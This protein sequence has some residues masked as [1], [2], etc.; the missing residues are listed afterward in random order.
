ML[1]KHAHTQHA[2]EKNLIR[3]WRHMKQCT[4][5]WLVGGLDGSGQ[6]YG[7]TTV[8]SGYEFHMPVAHVWSTIIYIYTF[9]YVEW[10]KNK[11]V[12]QRKK[13]YKWIWCRRGSVINNK[14][15][16][17]FLCIYFFFQL[18]ICYFEILAGVTVHRNL[19]KKSDVMKFQL[20]R[21]CTLFVLW[22]LNEL[23][24]TFELMK[25]GWNVSLVQVHLSFV[26]L[27]RQRIVGLQKNKY[28]MVDLVPMVGW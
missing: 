23:F 1:K 8:S 26:L 21:K 24:R 15:K 6:K 11:N 7:P 19:K 17:R 27:I 9:L 14:I 28:I 5:F 22:E 18:I 13:K 10:L 12:K 20:P 16:I 4:F 25:R 2:V 3:K